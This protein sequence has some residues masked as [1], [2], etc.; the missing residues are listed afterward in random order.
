MGTDA[1]RDGAGRLMAETTQMQ[2]G[3]KE[4]MADRTVRILVLCS[5]INSVG[6]FS[7]MPFLALYLAD[8]TTLPPAAIGAFTGSIALVGAVG[9]LA[10]GVITDRAGAGSL[11]RAGFALYTV[12]GAALAVVTAPVV[13]L[14]LIVC[15]GGA[16]ML[17][18]PS[19]KKLMSLAAGEGGGLVFRMRFMTLSVGAALGPLLGAA[20]YNVSRSAL[21]GVSAVLFVLCLILVHARRDALRALDVRSEAA[22]RERWAWTRSLRDARFR[23]VLLSS[24]LVTLVF[25]QFESMI[26]LY[27]KDEAGDSAPTLFAV[28]FAVHAV[29]GFVYQ[30]PAAW[31]ARRMSM[32]AQATVGCTGFAV[33]FACWG[34][35]AGRLWVLLAGVFAWTVGEAILM[36]MADL[37]THRIAPDEEKGAFFGALEIRY[38]GFFAGP[39]LGGALLGGGTWNYFGVMAAISFAAWP[40]L[41]SRSLTREAP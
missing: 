36:P 25:A 21:F 1:G 18:G 8:I 27:L 41:R 2:A 38:L 35:S 40:V 17:V 10:G 7:M 12:L 33:S 15:L 6:F 24:V 5:L 32:P 22:R 14:P 29:L 19:L 30:W 31:L 28:V 37:I 4:L 34:V 11:L 39:I 16:L 20:A 9:A 23:L 26:P 3:F 13:V